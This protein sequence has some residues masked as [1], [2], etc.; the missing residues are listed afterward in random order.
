[1]ILCLWVWVHT[2]SCVC[3]WVAYTFLYVCMYIWRSQKPMSN[4]CLH[5]FST[6][7]DYILRR[8]L[9]LTLEVTDLAGL[10]GI[11]LGARITCSDF[12]H[13]CWG[14]WTQVLTLT[15]QALYCLNYS[16]TNF[17]FKM[18]FAFLRL[19]L[20]IICKGLKCKWE[21]FYLKIMQLVRNILHFL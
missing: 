3:S 9:E 12:S 5:L 17:F 4:V 14:F 15:Q 21:H 20:G 18:C 13:R 1:M 2:C 10:G 11:L 19:N 16:Q 7:H 6:V 8:N